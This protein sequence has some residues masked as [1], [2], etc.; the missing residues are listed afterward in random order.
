MEVLLKHYTLVLTVIIAAVM[1][2]SVSAWCADA[3]GYINS[4]QLRIEYVGA[5][6]L[7]AQL[8]ASV[9]DWRAQA[10]ATEQE[11]QG[12]ISELTNQRLLLSEDAAAEK[13][14]A[15]QRKQLEFEEFMRSSSPYLALMSSEPGAL[16]IHFGQ[17]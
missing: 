2:I 11:I 14:M 8:E 1:F 16:D 15:I 10:R 7:D 17:V 13:E 6:D 3:V 4:E 5:G 12:L 9:A